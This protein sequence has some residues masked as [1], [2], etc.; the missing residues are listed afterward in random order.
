M[1]KITTSAP[2]KLMLFGE[3]AVV[4]GYPSIVTAMDTRIFVIAEMIENSSDIIIT[5]QVKE[6]RFLVESL[7]LFKEEFQVKQSVKLHTRSDFSHNVG[8]GSSSAVTVAAFKA[9]SLLF[10]KKLSK[11]EIFDLSYKVTLQI[12]GVGSGF[13]IAAATY[14]GT[15]HFIT[16]G[17]KI[18]YLDTEE[19]PLIVGYSGVKADTPTMIRKVENAFKNKKE[20]IG[21][22]FGEI[23]QIIGKAKEAIIDKDYQLTGNLMNKNHKLLVKLGVSTERLESMVN[24]SLASGAY[25]AKLSGAGG[26]DCMIALI[27][28]EKKGEVEKAIQK[29]GGTIIRVANNAEGTREEL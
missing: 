25:G 15:L 21:K 1:K 12:Q 6:S 10:D 27:S 7:K 13:D 5:P 29:V 23:E 20:E 11:K 24:A 22:I 14:G 3:H 9:L 26:G 16:G 17:K 4:Y 2:G 19:I 18:E 28:P 8:L